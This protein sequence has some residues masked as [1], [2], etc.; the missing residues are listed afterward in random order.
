MISFGDDKGSVGLELLEMEKV[1]VA[2]YPLHDGDLEWRDGEIP[3]DRQVTIV[4]V[5]ATP[6]PPI[7][8]LTRG[9]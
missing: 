6:P 8:H 9:K 1:F 2:A 5:V 3:N 4:K 7:C